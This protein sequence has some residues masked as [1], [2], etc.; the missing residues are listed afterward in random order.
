MS[1]F[2]YDERFMR[3][4]LELAALS[5]YSTHP[6]PMVGAVITDSKGR[7]IGE[8][9]HR[10]CG[11]G[12]A[13]VNAVASVK[14]K[15]LLKD[16]TMYVTLEPCSHYGKTPP[17][18]KLIIDCGIPR[19]VV[20]ATDPFAKVS[21]RGISMLR[22]AGVA[23]VT[24]VLAAESLELNRRFITAHTLKRPYITL[25]WAQSADGFMCAGGAA[26]PLSTAATLPLVHR[27]RG[28]HDAILT[29]A[30]TAVADG[31]R[32]DVRLW[33][34]PSPRRIILDRSGLLPADAPVITSTGTSPLHYAPA[35]CVLPGTEHADITKQSDLHQLMQDLYKR[36]ITSV[37]VEA[38]P[39]LLNAF[40]ADG[41]YDELRVETSPVK[42]GQRGTHPAPSIGRG[43]EDV[44]AEIRMSVDTVTV[45]GQTITVK[46]R[47]GSADSR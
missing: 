15:K 36:G 8:G 24:G 23:V 7:I 43:N 1:S 17:C 30:R 5:P 10:R 4:A 29:T 12:H 25:K 11:E 21:G 28:V 16:A 45:G 20:G 44:G 13:E 42:L 47:I 32:L 9:F 39:T 31:S 18:A 37:L 46:R 2:S 22:D 3:R 14:D 19:V 27:L 34:A 38:G 6:N 33:D 40:L 35:G 26:Y 41:L